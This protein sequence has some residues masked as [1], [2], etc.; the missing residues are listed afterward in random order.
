MNANSACQERLPKCPVVP[1]W[2]AQEEASSPDT[3]NVDKLRK[4]PR[5]YAELNQINRKETPP[6]PPPTRPFGHTTPLP[7]LAAACHPFFR[8][9][10]EEKWT[11]EALLASR[12]L[13]DTEPEWLIG[14]AALYL[15]AAMGTRARP[16]SYSGADPPGGMHILGGDVLQGGGQWTTPGVSILSGE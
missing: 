14:G 11:M 7:P 8:R 2:P 15:Q 4:L 6:P 9:Y 12:L 10:V 13:L 16:R 5:K 3:C 1:T